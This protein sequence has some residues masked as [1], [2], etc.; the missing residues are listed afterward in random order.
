MDWPEFALR[1]LPDVL[2]FSHEAGKSALGFS[3]RDAGTNAPQSS[4]GSGTR[5][6]QWARA[7]G[8]CAEKDQFAQRLNGQQVDRE[9]G[10]IFRETPEFGRS[11]ATRLADFHDSDTRGDLMLIGGGGEA[12]V[13]GDDSNQ[14]VA[15]LLGTSGK[16]QFG[17]VLDADAE[18]RWLLRPGNLAEALTRY[19]LAETHAFPSRLGIDSIGANGDF[20][21]LTQPFLVGGNP[22]E[23]QLAAWMREQGWQ[24]I[25][26]PT[27]L[28]MLT[29][30][31]WQRANLVATDVRPENAIVA[32][33][34]GD[35]YPFDF[36][37]AAV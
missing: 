4:A 18:G 30:L 14:Q 19:W 35:I 23:D 5:V 34:D 11:L 7:A 12:V 22:T 1:N 10:E 27:E 9:L 32:E 33:S 21:I 29:Q 28:E 26:P 25:S 31:T 37:V 3:G 13:F 24:R 8:R 6:T 15:K 16:A 20:V 36:V 17:W 2:G